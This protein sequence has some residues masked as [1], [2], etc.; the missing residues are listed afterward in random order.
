MNLLWRKERD[1]GVE[2]A[3]MYLLLLDVSLVAWLL[4]FQVLSVASSRFAKSEK[5]EAVLTLD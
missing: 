3:A 1:E 2:A 5:L 4:M